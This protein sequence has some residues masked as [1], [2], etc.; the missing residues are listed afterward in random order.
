MYII[1]LTGTSFIQLDFV[2]IIHIVYN[3]IITFLLHFDHNRKYP[4][5][6]RL[7]VYHDSQIGLSEILHL[8]VSRNIKRRLN[9]DILTSKFSDHFSDKRLNGIQ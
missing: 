3:K 7:V 2:F 9:T 6:I 4:N 8:F 1:L 5:S